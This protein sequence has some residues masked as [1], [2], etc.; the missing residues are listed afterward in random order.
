MKFV[1]ESIKE[2]FK[3]TPINFKSSKFEEH[4]LNDIYSYDEGAKIKLNRDVT[5]DFSEEI[6]MYKDEK[7]NIRFSVMGETRSGKSLTCLKIGDVILNDSIVQD[8][9]KDIDK[10]VCGNQ[11]EYRQKLM[12]AQKDEFYLVDENL[13]TSSGI[14]SNIEISQLKDVNSIIAKKNISVL[15]INPERFLNV[16]ATLGLST[17]GRDSKNW[18]SRCL[19]YKFK[20]SHPHLVGFVVLD[21]GEL[22]RKY[23]CFIYKFNGGCTNSKKLIEKDVPLQVIKES[24]CIKQKYNKDELVDDKTDCPFYNICSHPLNSY[25][26]KK[27]LWIDA[28]MKGSLDD[29]TRERFRVAVL[30][31][32]DLYK[33]YDEK[34]QS[35]LLNAKNGK[36]LKNRVRLKAVRHSSTKWGIAE[37]D[38]LVELIKTN[39]DIDFLAETLDTLEEKEILNKFFNLEVAGEYIR[40]AFD[41]LPENFIKD[42]KES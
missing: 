34:K 20:S 3:R 23:G 12:K 8:F 27:D 1:P 26:R 13:F 33:E 31:I 9:N 35:L 2:H 42:K 25:E 11:V 22:F 18:L 40:G 6:K 15:F 17:Y 30:V 14:G 10:I 4:M 24:Y 37:F 39:C 21:I 36:D 41:N 32:F 16:G 5:K 19:V 38:E 28:E 29:R 7:R